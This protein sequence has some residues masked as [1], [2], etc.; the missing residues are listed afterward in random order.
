MKAVRRFKRKVRAFH[1]QKVGRR[2]GLVAAQARC[3]RLTVRERA[4]GEKK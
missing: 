1:A 4:G 3:N 2:R